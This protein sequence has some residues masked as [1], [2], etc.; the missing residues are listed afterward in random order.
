M[1][2]VRIEKFALVFVGLLYSVIGIIFQIWDA[3]RHND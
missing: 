2:D 1:Q 3:V